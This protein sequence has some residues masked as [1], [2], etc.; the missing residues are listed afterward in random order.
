[1]RGIGAISVIFASLKVPECEEALCM[2]PWTAKGGC[3]NVEVD[4]AYV[5]LRKEPTVGARTRRT[6]KRIGAPA[7]LG[8]RMTRLLGDTKHACICSDF[9]PSPH[10][11]INISKHGCKQFMPESLGRSGLALSGVSILS[12]P[13]YG[14]GRSTR[15]LRSRLFANGRTLPCTRG[16]SRIVHAAKPLS[17]ARPR[18]HCRRLRSRVSRT[19]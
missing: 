3:G 1:M 2:K 15:S 10:S 16:Q 4:Y 12:V 6:A 19:H 8:G 7:L 13:A 9:H 18:N 17:D 5:G 14:I 11:R